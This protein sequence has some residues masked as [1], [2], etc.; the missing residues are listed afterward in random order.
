MR[1][2]LDELQ[3]AVRGLARAPGFTALAVCVLGLGLGATIFMYGVVDAL[4][5][6]PPPFPDAG[7]IH[8]VTER[9]P[10]S[11]ELDPTLSAKDYVAIKDSIRGIE[12]IGSVY[13]GTVYLTGDGPAER[14]DG[15][16]VKS[17]LL[18][19][20]GVPPMLGRLV[21]ERDTLPGAPPVVVLSHS[22]WKERYGADP[23]VVGRVLR[24]NGQPTEVVG[25]MPEGF[26]FPSREMLWLADT[27]DPNATGKK[28]GVDVGTYIRLAPG[29]SPDE[30]QASL[31]PVAAATAGADPG[32]F[33]ERSFEV[34]PFAGSWV[35]TIGRM[36]L[37]TLLAAVGFVLLIACA[38]VSNLL[39]ARAAYRVR[40]ATVRAAVGATRGRLVLHMLAESLV[41]TILAAALG[42]LLASIALD[43]MWM[44]TDRMAGE[45]PKWLSFDIDGRI[46][47]ATL[48]AGFVATLLAGLPAA[49]RA[50]RPSLDS[51]LRDGGRTGTGLAI[52]RI[53]WTLVVVEIT[54]ACTLLGGAALMTRSVMAV[55]HKD[56]GVAT[57]EIMTAR[58]GLPFGTYPDEQD[59]VG[60]FERFQARL[61]AQPEIESA[62]LTQSLPVHGAW[63]GPYSTGG[64]YEGDP[65]SMPQ[66]RML[67]V[68]PSLFDTFRLPALSGRVLLD[69]DRPDSLRVA[70]VS[71]ALVR[72]AFPDGQAVGQRLR[73]GDGAWPGRE[74]EQDEADWVTVVG[75]VRDVLYDDTGETEPAIYVPVA[76]D[77]QRFMSIAVRGAGGPET[78]A[79]AMRRALAETDPNLALYWVRTLDEGILQENFGFRIIGTLFAIFG[80]IALVLAAAGLFGVLSFHVGQR[81]REIGV[82]RALGASDRGI[83]T[84]VARASGT[85]V[86]VGLLLGM[87]LLPVLGRVLSPVLVDTS[88]F[89][90]AIYLGVLAV[91]L[92]VSVAAVLRPTLRA[93]RVDPA[94]ALRYE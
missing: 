2:M 83:L 61:E 3:A 42:L 76:Q 56:V 25:V 40:E 23:G 60:F 67:Q 72:E 88:P 47:A 12:A 55:A 35:G 8:L 62:A 16:F 57:G 58:V 14:Y 33:A 90:P 15:G 75:V 93:L 73:W 80:V 24:L 6:K 50:T 74:G 68:T 39:L 91:M 48:L 77:V 37:L 82:R 4:V 32:K 89:D 52:G 92:V 17:G 10:R 5:L 26:H 43:V 86:A 87:A 78:L 28:E 51:L 36:L 69:S 13:Q 84:M 30:V 9:W 38:N 65:A 11:I 7:R 54:L 85:Q 94:A 79:G 49:V 29:T 19:V 53:A 70:V 66:A 21:E 71:E 45:S 46:V 34:I 59:Q 31:A 41:I 63:K 20:A 18:E 44:A 81:T 64:R 1:A 22:L 27:Q